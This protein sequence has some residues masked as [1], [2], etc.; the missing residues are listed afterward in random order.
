MSLQLGLF[1]LAA[2]DTC[3]ADA[4]ALGAAIYL[5]LY[6]AEVDVPAPLGDVVRM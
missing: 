1:D 3:G 5:C 4:Q 2:L 6:R